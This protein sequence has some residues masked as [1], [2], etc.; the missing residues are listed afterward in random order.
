MA[1]S[2]LSSKLGSPSRTSDGFDHYASGKAERMLE[3]A[4][5]R[6]I[7]LVMRNSQTE[8]G[9]VVAEA[10]YKWTEVTP[11][12]YIRWKTVASRT[13]AG[14]GG[15]SHSVLTLSNIIIDGKEIRP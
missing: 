1:I 5:D 14:S 11:D 4:V 2:A 15:T 7:N 8:Q 9:K 10:A 6:G 3:V 13:S 12:M